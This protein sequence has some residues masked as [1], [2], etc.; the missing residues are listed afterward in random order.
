MA[1]S[2]FLRVLLK[3][4]EKASTRVEQVSHVLYRSTCT[5]T[6]PVRFQAFRGESEED[7]QH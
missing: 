6:C 1:S 4:K 5:L 7:C 2:R 3:L